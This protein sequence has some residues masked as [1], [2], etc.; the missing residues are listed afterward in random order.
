MTAG[1]PDAMRKA[2]GA[3]SRRATPWLVALTL[4]LA[5]AARARLEPDEQ[6][7]RLRDLAFVPSRFWAMV[8]PQSAERRLEDAARLSPDLAREASYWLAG[9]HG[10]LN[11][12]SYAFAHLDWTHVGVNAGLLALFGPAAARRFSA[13]GFLALLAFGA[14]AGA[15]AQ[16]A[17]QASA[18]APLIGASASVCALFGALARQLAEPG[19][20]LVAAALRPTSAAALAAGVVALVVAGVEG[21]PLSATPAHLGG[22]LAGFAAAGPLA[23]RS[24]RGE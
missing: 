14:A 15:L 18:L 5:H 22:F 6:W 20:S 24:A 4:A 17:S 23:A 9:G 21:G 2:T 10:P 16:S 12:V 1:G 8:A 13:P 11:L 3:W 19:D 7:R